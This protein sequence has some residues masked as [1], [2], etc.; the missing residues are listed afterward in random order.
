M[1]S[2]LLTSRRISSKLLWISLSFSLPI[3]VLLY[4]MIAGINKDIQFAQQELAGNSY[5]RP[6]HEL[7]RHVSRHQWLSHGQGIAESELASERGKIDQDFQRLDAVQ[8]LL[9][10]SLQVTED[11]LSQRQRSHSFPGEMAAAWQKFQAEFES[12]GPAVSDAR[13]RQL[14]DNARQ[15]VSHVG[16]TSNLI[17][18]PD[19][20]SYYL[21]DVSLLGLPRLQ[22]RL[23]ELRL[24]AG[25]SFT[26]S[27]LSAADVLNLA[28]TARLLREADFDAVVTSTRTALAEDLNFHGASGSIRQI[29]PA[30]DNFVNSME[31]F[32]SQLEFTEVAQFEGRGAAID[33][34]LIRA[35]DAS[36]QLREVVARELDELL[37]IRI[38]EYKYNRI[39][40]LL[41]TSLALAVSVILVVFVA[42]SIT[43][44]LSNCVSGLQA[45][46]SRDLTR[47]LN[48]RS[49]SEI[50][51]ISTAVD[52]AADGMMG[53]MKSLRAS[54]IELNQAADRQ[55][56]VSG[57][58]STTAEQTS[59]QAQRASIVAEQVSQN[60]QAVSLAVSELS[61]AIRE[62][63]NNTQQ[64]A[65]VA[66]DAVQLAAATNNTVTKLGH[67]SA[68]IGEVIKV[69]TSIA[70][71]TNLLSLNATIEAAR[72]GEAGKGFAVVANAVKE[73]AKQTAHATETIRRKIDATQ[74]DIRDS[75][76]AISRISHTIEQINDFQNSIA[77]AVE[78]QTVVTRDISRNV[79]DAAKGT[80]EIAGNIV[81]VARAAE[82]TAAG[83][84]ATR[85][86]A[87]DATRLASQL[88][89]LVSLF[90]SE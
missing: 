30:L 5:Q 23:A 52:Q 64:A 6:L 56:E 14:R 80:A 38:R 25:T 34:S 70:E 76:T 84:M 41:L 47:R 17:L 37:R 21:M 69:I 82:G 73:L 75:V 4:F 11:G 88:N 59:Q 22:N 74:N 66:T 10:D 55:T 26:K 36:Y 90:R 19:L 39:W 13:Y 67:S 79:A 83:S 63:A 60:T 27:E 2:N 89:E 65:R 77:G 29:E 16:D 51:E 8:R 54:A 61:T 49:D 3:A 53:A 1:S 9:G 68:E 12:L 31:D 35:L 72:A 43:R 33:L 7:L 50:G 24:S 86:A 15:L 42:R 20:D 71:Q 57:Q 81:Q 44:P 18:D 48:F 87:Q 58:M 62:I 40:S 32:L 85:A 78:E 46:A 28:S 45:L